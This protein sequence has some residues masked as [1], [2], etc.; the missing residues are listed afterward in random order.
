MKNQNEDRKEKC[1]KY[2]TQVHLTVQSLLYSTGLSWG[3]ACCWKDMPS[4]PLCANLSQQ[5]F[6]AWDEILF[7][8]DFE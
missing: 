8:C 6:L 3:Q 4:L 5:L 7:V 1:G 2:R